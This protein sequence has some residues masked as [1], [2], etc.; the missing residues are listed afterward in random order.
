MIDITPFVERLRLARAGSRST[1]DTSRPE[2]SVVSTEIDTQWEELS[3]A[4]EELRVQNDQLAA[5]QEQIERERRRYRNLFDLAPD[6]HFLTDG[7]GLVLQA[8]AAGV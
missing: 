2:P 5:T 7:R 8:N 1:G 4:V 3:T 6:A